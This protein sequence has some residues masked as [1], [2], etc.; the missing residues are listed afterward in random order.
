ML[1]RLIKTEKD[2][3]L[4]DSFVIYMCMEGS[5]D[6]LDQNQC[7]TSV[8]KGETILVPAELKNII[9]TRCV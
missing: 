8:V 4:I 6:L 1:N 2:Y 7:N 3:N 9:L 5:F